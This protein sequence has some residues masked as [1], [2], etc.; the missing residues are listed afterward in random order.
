MPIIQLASWPSRVHDGNH[1]ERGEWA[2]TP[3]RSS[4]SSERESPISFQPRPPPSSPPVLSSLRYPFSSSP[5]LRFLAQQSPPFGSTRRPFSKPLLLQQ[6]LNQKRATL[7]GIAMPSSTLLVSSLEHDGRSSSG[8]ALSSSSA[9]APSSLTSANGSHDP[10]MLSAFGSGYAS[11]PTSISWTVRS[12][13]GGWGRGGTGLSAGGELKDQSDEELE[14]FGVGE[15]VRLLRAQWDA[16]E[17]V[18]PPCLA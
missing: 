1:D 10:S 9:S 12:K 11:T 5:P 15:L 6:E 17:R 3:V 14:R 13:P 18:S 4:A 16:G 7:S 8:S 2:R